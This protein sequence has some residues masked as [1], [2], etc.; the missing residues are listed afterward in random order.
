MRFLESG[1]GHELLLIGACEQQKLCRI[2]G[3]A[4]HYWIDSEIWHTTR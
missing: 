1:K 4:I 2:A 3:K